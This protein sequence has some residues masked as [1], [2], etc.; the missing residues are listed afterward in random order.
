MC[1]PSYI[2]RMY[3]HASFLSAIEKKL[4]YF[5]S[6]TFLSDSFP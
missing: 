5:V 4:T 6:E 3:L 2:K 1:K